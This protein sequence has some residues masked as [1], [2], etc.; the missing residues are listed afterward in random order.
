MARIVRRQPKQEEDNDMS[1]E[2]IQLAVKVHPE[3]LAML[4]SESELTGLHQKEIARDILRKWAERQAHISNVRTK[5]MKR[6][7]LSG[8]NG[9]FEE[10]QE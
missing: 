2:L 3:T 6:M 9:D 4:R 8:I 10:D 1:L 5:H 7:G